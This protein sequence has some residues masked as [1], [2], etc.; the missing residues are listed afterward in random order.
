MKRLVSDKNVLKGPKL[1]FSSGC[2]VFSCDQDAF[3][4][5]DLFVLGC[6]DDNVNAS[7]FINCVVKLAEPVTT[8]RCPMQN[9]HSL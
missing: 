7:Y 9:C 1:K 2:P 4:S 6:F 8:C 5:W 3:F